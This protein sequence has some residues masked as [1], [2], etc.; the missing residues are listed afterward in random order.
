MRLISKL[1]CLVVVRMWSCSLLTQDWTWWAADT[2]W[3]LLG[4]CNYSLSLIVISTSYSRIV[5]VVILLMNLI[6]TSPYLIPLSTVPLCAGN[7][8]LSPAHRP[9]LETRLPTLSCLARTSAAWA[10][11]STLSCASRTQS[12]V[13]WKRNTRNKQAERWT[14]LRTRK[15][16]CLLSVS[17]LAKYIECYFSECST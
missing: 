9:S 11:R 4:T 10:L 17:P 14:S 15:L 13:R 2:A 1:G 5:H 3:P 6:Q 7:N 16:I 8:S 12:L